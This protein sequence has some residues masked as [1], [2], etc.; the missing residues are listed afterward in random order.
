MHVVII[1]AGFTGVQL[2]RILIADNHNVVLVDN[3]REVARKAAERLDCTL[4]CA[5]GNNLETLEKAGIDKA[6]FLVCLSSSDEVNM[7]TCSLVDTVYPDVVKIARVRNYAYYANSLRAH[8]FLSDG[9]KGG[10][11]RAL[12]GIDF[13]IHP[14]F[15]AATSIVEAVEAG[16]LNNVLTFEGSAMQL[17]R[18]RVEKESLFARRKLL[19]I[20]NLTSVPLLIAYIETS[21]GSFLPSGETAIEAGSV[22]GVLSHKDDVGEI[23]KFCG[24]SKREIKNIAIV[25]AGRIGRLVAEKLLSKNED[26]RDGNFFTRLFKKAKKKKRQVIIIDRDETLALQ[27]AES[28]PEARVECA[29]AEDEVF[30][31]EEGITKCDLAIS[32]THNH[33]INLVLSAF[34]QAKGVANTIAL[35]QSGAFAAIA[36]KL[37][38]NATVSL[39]DVVVDSIISHMRGKAVKEVHTV[40]TGDLEIIECELGNREIDGKSMRELSHAGEFLVLLIKHAGEEEYEIVNGKSVFRL[41]DH[42]VLIAHAEKSVEVISLFGRA[43]E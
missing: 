6:T 36:H 17:S 5:D 2:S 15:E 34:L 13:M 27:A 25:G 24:S 23:L 28:F 39:R 19:E 9:V 29:D 32:A 3:D 42:L 20:R 41:G 1:G 35:V 26:E 30:L 11:H 40:T 31:E 7:I 21:E 37:G 12:Y 14:D 16:S 33:E 22:V 8:N 18:L 10:S 38:I 4:L 43:G